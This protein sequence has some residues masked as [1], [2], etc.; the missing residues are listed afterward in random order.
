MKLTFIGVGSA[1]AHE[2]YQSNMIL[3]IN[4]KRLLIDAGGT[5]HR[6]LKALGLTHRDLDAVYISHLHADHCG[7]MEWLAFST[8]FDSGF[9]DAKGG[10][11]KLRLFIRSTLAQKLWN[12]VMR[13][14]CASLE[15][16]PNTLATYFDLTRCGYN[17]KFQFEGT[18]F[19]L[20]QTIH[21]VNEREIVPSYGLFWLGANGKKIFLTT[22]TQF[23][24]HSIFTFYKQADVILHDCETT[25]GFKT[26]IHAHYT[27]LKT[28]PADIR[29]KMYLYHYQDGAKPD[30]VADGF[31]GWITQGQSFDFS[32]TN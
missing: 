4:G 15:G 21:Y 12:E 2:N 8:K 11:K 25:V 23:A 10:K 24:P 14:G 5:A 30:A 17:G 28:L 18:A 32:A 26:G 19:E 13:G 29:A 31:G 3:E 16:E 9:V 7:S 27:D 6:A 22:D 20:V 1:F